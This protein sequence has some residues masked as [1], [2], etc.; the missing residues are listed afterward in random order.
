MPNVIE[1]GYLGLLKNGQ[2]KLK[3]VKA[4]EL[5]NICELCPHICKVDRKINRGICRAGQNAVVSNY[6]PHFGEE[7]PLVGRRG[8]GTIFFAYCNMRCVFCQNYDI[9]WEGNGEELSADELADIMLNLQKKGC[10]NVNLVTPTHYVPQIL[11]A[12]DIAA[13]KGL[14]IPL[15]YN[16]GGYE[17][18][19]TLKILNG[20]VDIYMPD[21]KYNNSEIAKMYSGVSDYPEK[22]KLALKEMYK[23]VGDLIVDDKGIAVKGL[24]V[25][26]LVLPKGLSGTK[27]IMEF[28]ATNLSPRTF[29]NVMRQYYPHYK[30]IYHRDIN[31]PVT[32]REFEEAV[33]YAKDAGL[34]PNT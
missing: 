3:V 14:N 2:L 20:V 18:L 1:P 32:Q 27:E 33:K 10:H 28:I 29:V 22:V 4:Y 31:R 17:R 34:V 11:E 7:G 26:H 21:V 12:L 24:I 30:A 23:Q 19:E 15:V 9:S 8:S 6:G 25:R 16:C 13:N 5:F